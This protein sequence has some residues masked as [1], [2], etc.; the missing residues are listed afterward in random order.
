MGEEE[1]LSAP[2][3]ARYDSDIIS[4]FAAKE[5]TFFLFFKK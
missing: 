5:N 1:A 4:D 2:C 3:P